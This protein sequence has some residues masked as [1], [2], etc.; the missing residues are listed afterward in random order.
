MSTSG[1]KY[2]TLKAPGILVGKL[3]WSSFKVSTI[4]YYKYLQAEYRLTL[5]MARNVNSI[6]FDF[7]IFCAL[8][9]WST[10]T[11]HTYADL[12]PLMVRLH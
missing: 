1:H 11:Q 6:L 12:Q 5:H 8:S 3:D 10:S 7:L 2:H 9:G 4:V